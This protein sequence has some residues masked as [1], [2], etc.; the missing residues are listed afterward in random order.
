MAHVTV[1][2]PGKIN[3]IL[4]VGPQNSSGYHDLLTVFQGV[5]LWETVR[6]E[7]AAE[8]SLTVS[9]DVLLDEIPLDDT[10]LVIRAAKAVARITG[11][12]GAAAFHIDKR[13]PVGGGMA[14]GSADAAASLIAVDALWGTK[15]SQVQLLELASEL[16]SD[17]PFAL[18]GY[19]QVGR[20]RG[21]LLEG[22]ESL[23]FFW[24]VVPQPLHL[25]TPLV[26]STLDT[27]RGDEVPVLPEAPSEALLDA[28]F[29]GDAKALAAELVNDLAA[30]ALMVA[31]EIQNALNLGT[32]LGALAGMVSGSG[33]TC[34]FLAEDALHQARLVDGFESE[35]HYALRASSPARG[36]HLPRA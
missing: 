3:L 5:D 22:V 8:F 21:H 9:G 19:T 12:D 35:G 1:K 28:L 29:T 27:L 26:Y 24:V 4:H 32:Q 13:V 20:G 36:A 16:G 11:Y 33:P 34:V 10:N 30:P 2:A 6:A 15:L 7:D 14:G 17:V 25:S 18:E 31:P 23:P